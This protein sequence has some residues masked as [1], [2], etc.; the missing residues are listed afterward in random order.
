MREEIFMTKK[1]ELVTIKAQTIDPT[2]TV[3]QV[4]QQ[5]I[6]QGKKN[7]QLSHEEIADKLS[8]FQMDADQMDE[9]FDEIN[10]QEIQL[11]NEKDSND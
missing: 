5:L 9:F 4:R 6:E 2:L 1:D 7:G 8:N 3:E 11:I 10:A